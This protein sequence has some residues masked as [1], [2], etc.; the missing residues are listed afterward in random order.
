ME[1]RHLANLVRARF[2]VQ[3]ANFLVLYRHARTAPRGFVAGGTGF[4]RGPQLGPQ[5]GHFRVRLALPRE[6]LDAEQPPCRLVD[7]APAARAVL[8]GYGLG[9]RFDKRAQPLIAVEQLAFGAA[10]A[11]VGAQQRDKSDPG[12]Q[13]RQKRDRDQD[14][15]V[16]PPRGDAVPKRKPE[17]RSKEH[18]QSHCLPDLRRQA[19]PC[20]GRDCH[21]TQY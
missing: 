21:G 1:Q 15:G 20:R 11:G 16:A 18:E 8:Q 12:D 14:A 5:H 2:V 9:Q 3:P 7:R 13:L 6:L 17:G 4:V 10:S 19:G